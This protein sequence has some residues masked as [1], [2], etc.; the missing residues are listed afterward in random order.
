MA[1][2]IKNDLVADLTWAELYLAKIQEN[3]KILTPAVKS[4]PIGTGLTESAALLRHQLEDA[5]RT[6]GGLRKML[7]R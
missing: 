5:H 4:A 3:L 6:A 2:R 1:K 7:Q